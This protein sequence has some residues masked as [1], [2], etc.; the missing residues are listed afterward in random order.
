MIGRE[1]EDSVGEAVVFEPINDTELKDVVYS[2]FCILGDDGGEH[3]S[4]KQ[5]GSDVIDESL[6][7]LSLGTQHEPSDMQ[8]FCSA[9][10]LHESG[11]HVLSGERER[12]RE[13]EIKQK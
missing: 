7:Q 10:Q 13:R 3:R 4:L 11:L 12:E 2:F 1:E 9:H 6:Q 8:E 5:D